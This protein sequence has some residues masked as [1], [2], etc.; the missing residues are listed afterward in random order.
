MHN[1]TFGFDFR[2]GFCSF[3]L[4]LLV[5]SLLSDLGLSD[6]FNDDF[7]TEEEAIGDEAMTRNLVT[8]DFRIVNRWQSRCYLDVYYF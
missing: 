7:W 8:G 2:L 1:I 3:A 4:F 5:N 6:F